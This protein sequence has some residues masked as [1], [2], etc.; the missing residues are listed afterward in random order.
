MIK[1][2]LLVSLTLSFIFLGCADTPPGR[3]SSSEAGGVVNQQQQKTQ[4]RMMRGNMPSE[5]GPGSF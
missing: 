4:Q 3:P 2:A 1:R 5:V